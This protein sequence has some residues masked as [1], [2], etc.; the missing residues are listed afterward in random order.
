MKSSADVEMSVAPIIK[1]C[2]E[3]IVLASESINEKED[4]QKVIEKYVALL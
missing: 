2:L 1:R 4:S 3:G